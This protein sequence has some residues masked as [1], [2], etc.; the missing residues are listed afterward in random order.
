M[1]EPTMAALLA[2]RHEERRRSAGA[3]V[4]RQAKV[5]AKADEELNRAAR[6]SPMCDECE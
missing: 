5:K 1:I 4:T 2:A 3:R 6:V